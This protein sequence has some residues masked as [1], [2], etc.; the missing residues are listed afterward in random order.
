MR[1]VQHPTTHKL[2][3]SNEV[4]WHYGEEADYK[5]LPDIEP[6]K[7]PVDGKLVLGR[8]SLREHNKRNG[9]ENTREF[10]GQKEHVRRREEARIRRD[11]HQAAVDAVIKHGVRSD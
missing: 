2:V 7:S 11:Q 3:P 1:Y 4:D 9:V 6:F 5:I 10:D 8:A